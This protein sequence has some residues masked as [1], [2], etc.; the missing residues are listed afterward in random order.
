[1]LE[2]AHQQPATTQATYLREYLYVAQC[3]AEA[4][5]AAEANATGS[6]DGGGSN[7]GVEGAEGED[8]LATG[9]APV[10][11]DGAVAA[12]VAAAAMLPAG[13]SKGAAVAAVLRAGADEGLPLPAIDIGDVYVHFQAGPLMVLDDCLS[14]MYDCETSDEDAVSVY[15]YTGTHAAHR[16]V[17]LKR[18]RLHKPCR[19]D[20]HLTATTGGGEP[21]TSTSTS[22]STAYS[23]PP[24][25]PACS[26]WPEAR[27]VRPGRCCSALHRAPFALQNGGSMSPG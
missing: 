3:A 9:G 6:S 18:E 21:S 26:S 16:Q 17:D 11:G 1:L 22:T 12:A 27:W 25:T 15:R 20:G 7:G 10:D 5:A 14:I 13:E 8:V 23:L 4:A 19:Q 2:C 24:F